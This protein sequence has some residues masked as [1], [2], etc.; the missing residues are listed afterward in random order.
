M[1]RMRAVREKF[2]QHVFRTIPCNIMDR[3]HPP[4]LPRT[5]PKRSYSVQQIK[6]DFGH[7]EKPPADAD[8]LGQAA[9][10]FIW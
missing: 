1:R 2:Q 6:A 5:E 10:L 9:Y 4:A 7:S 3:F 8:G